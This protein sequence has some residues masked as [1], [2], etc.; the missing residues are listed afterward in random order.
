MGKAASLRELIANLIA[1]VDVSSSQAQIGELGRRGL[2]AILDV[3]EDHS[4]AVPADRH[5]R[6]LYE[7]V[8]GTL[9]KIAEV[10]PELLI[11]A[12]QQR[13]AHTFTLIWNLGASRQESARLTLAEYAGH[14]DPLVRWAAVSGLSR[15]RSKRVVPKL[16]NAL[17][18]RS[19]NVRFAA[20]QGLTRCA[21]Q[22]AIAPLQR[23]LSD[24]RLL[25]GARRIAEELLNRLESRR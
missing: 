25:P 10:D 3:R 23:Y 19:S 1:G 20:L 8:T 6:D 4:A 17:R 5:P 11:A 12:L 21:D 13:P 18:D 9:W 2:N 22:S 15:S 16:V 7:D 14:K 24:K